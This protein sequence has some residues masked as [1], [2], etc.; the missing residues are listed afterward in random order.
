MKRG[1]TLTEL[2]LT[3]AL[4]VTV[5]G[6]ALPRLQRPLERLAVER[7]VYD[8]AAAHFRA[9]T[10]AVA[11]NRVTILQIGVDSIRMR[12][13][14]G[15][16]T[17]TTWAREGSG[18]YGVAMTGSPHWLRFHPAGIGFGLSN[19]SWTFSRGTATRVVTVSRLGRLRISP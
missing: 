7:A 16:D 17:M 2:M 18:A 1:F 6:I 14:A 5:A 4:M 11:R 12:I 3:V 19:G 13:L 10:T 9:R 8:V 15:K